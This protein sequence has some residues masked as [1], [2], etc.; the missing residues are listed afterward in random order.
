MQLK[1]LIIL[2]LY[3]SHA[4]LYCF[5]LFISCSLGNLTTVKHY[6]L[7]IFPNNIYTACAE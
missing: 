2:V 1:Q 4:F 7:L 5:P 6:K 3:Y